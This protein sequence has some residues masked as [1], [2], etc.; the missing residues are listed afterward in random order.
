MQTFKFAHIADAHIGH[1]QW[2]GEIKKKRREDFGNAFLYAIDMMIYHAVDFVVDAGDLVD[3]QFAPE[4]DRSFVREGL[5]RLKQSGIPYYAID[6]NHNY[7]DSIDGLSLL[8]EL[9]DM[10]LVE[11]VGEWAQVSLQDGI[12]I[13]ICG[14]P[15]SGAA[16][17]SLLSSIGAPDFTSHYNILVA[18]CGLEGLMPQMY[19]ETVPL[20]TFY[21]MK[22]YIDYVALGHIHKPFNDGFI[23]MPG[24][25]EVLNK[26]EANYDG[27][28]NIVTVTIDDDGKATTEVEKVGV[29]RR[30]WVF[31]ESDVGKFDTT[32]ELFADIQDQIGDEGFSHFT[33]EP[34]VVVELTGGKTFRVNRQGIRESMAKA[35]G[36]FVCQIDDNSVPVGVDTDV[37]LTGKLASEIEVEF[38]G[39]NLGDDAQTALEIKR[40][41]LAGF[42][43][44]RILEVL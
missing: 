33:K 43:S 39:R 8:D 36:V 7:K 14:L 1:G 30:P 12:S 18:H 24:S 26:G 6:G 37:E 25:P 34:I 15:W 31:L 38:F 27:G 22:S 2:W 17:Q 23:R 13:G 10:G 32:R 3:K 35:Y 21:G 19:P 4:W 44:E 42:D 11:Q 40:L 16:T 41:V 9:E 20:E 5:N 28:I 29:P